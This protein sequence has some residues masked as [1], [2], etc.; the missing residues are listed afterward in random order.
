MACQPAAAEEPDAE[1]RAGWK[2]LAELGEGFVVWESSRSGHWR[3]WRRDLDGSG[4]RQ[5][6]PD[7][8]GREHYCPH[9]SPDGTRLVYLSYPSGT[10]TYDHLPP[11]GGV[12]YLL[13]SEGGKPKRLAPAARAYFEDR[14]AVWLDNDRL[15]YIDGQGYSVELDLRSGKSIAAD[16]PGASESRLSG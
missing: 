14:G 4:L 2:R 11:N 13:R 7:E 16:C 1:T 12:L 3:L 15:V 8:Q 10:D 9:L 5:I 6:S